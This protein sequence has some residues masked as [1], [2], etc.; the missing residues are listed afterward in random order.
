M[1]FQKIA[2]AGATGFLGRKVLAHLLTISTVKRIT[3]L[4]RSNSI[5]DFPTLP[6]LSVVSIPSYEDQTALTSILRG[7]DLVISTIG[8]VAAQILDPV[9]LSAAVSAGVQRFMPSEYTLDVMHPHAIAVA[10][11]TVLAGRIR[12]AQAIQKL[13]EAG[14]IE[15]TTIVSGAI[16][17]WWFENGD[18]GV[19]MRRKKVTLY[20][21]GEKEV[22]GST[23][24]FIS[25]C[26]GAIVT[27]PPETTKNRRIRIAE[28]KYS[29][30]EISE[31]FQ[32]VTGEKW[33]VDERS[34]DTLLNEG[35]K[36]G[37][38]GD[39][40]GLYLSHILALNFDGE[41]AAFFREGLKFRGGSVKRRS[42]RE[43]V[44]RFVASN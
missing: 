4:T 43:I 39:L 26:V 6:I 9:L 31:A 15:Y 41:G 11:S 7:H 27:M 21:G 5:P 33:E 10:G 30:E 29:G 38:K 23:T 2:V 24:D 13:A 40:R 14:E 35:K 34:T 8:G 42:L 1:T 19:D 12:N 3:V 16:L 17:D 28:V 37:V 36:A 20:D 22:T 18:L 44:K 25:H 32:E